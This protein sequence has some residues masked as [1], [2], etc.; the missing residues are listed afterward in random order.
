MI[1][2]K[3]RHSTTHIVKATKDGRISEI[4]KEISVWYGT[5]LEIK[6]KRVR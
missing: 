1:K 3:G 2:S 6:I 5:E 4:E